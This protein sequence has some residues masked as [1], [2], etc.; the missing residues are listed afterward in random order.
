MSGSTE[1][2]DDKD[3]VI[4]DPEKDGAEEPGTEDDGGAVISEGESMGDQESGG[5]GQ[6]NFAARITA[7]GSL[8][9]RTGRKRSLLMPGTADDC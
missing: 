9:S 2:S 8:R 6:E 5:S 1:E 4:S 3:A 7:R